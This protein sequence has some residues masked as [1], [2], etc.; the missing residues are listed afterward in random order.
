MDPNITPDQAQERLADVDRARDAVAQ[1]IRM[2]GWYTAAYAGALAVLFVV[3]GL[4]S[5]PGHELSAS[6][7]R[8]AI[9][10]AVVVLVLAEA[11]LRR[12]TGTRLRPDRATAYVSARRPILLTGGIVLLGSAITWV[13]AVAVSWI[14]SIALGLIV[15]ALAVRGQRETADAIGRDIRAG[16]VVPR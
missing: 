5:W 6:A 8:I 3:P 1:R 7:V 10:S 12:S 16:R 14:L 15:V 4:S 13:T 2:P 9:L 11:A